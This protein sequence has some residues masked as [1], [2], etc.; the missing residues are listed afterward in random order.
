MENQDQME[1]TAGE[2]T[3]QPQSEVAEQA[4]ASPELTINDLINIRSVI[5]VAVR[6]GT[7]GAAVVSAVG[8]TFDRLNVF[9]NAVAPPTSNTPPAQ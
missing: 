7:F 5:E 2:N 1:S 9:L 4:A 8:A 6:R 3:M